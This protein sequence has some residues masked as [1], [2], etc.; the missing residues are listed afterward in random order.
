MRQLVLGLVASVGQV[1]AIGVIGGIVAS[2][3]ACSSS[4]APAIDAPRVDAVV[5]LDSARADAAVDAP[6]G[7]FV[8]TS[9]AWTEGNAIPVKHSCQGTN[10]SPPLAWTAAAGQGYA[11]VITDKSNALVHSVMWDIPAATQVLPE[12]IAK[13][14]EPPVPVGAKQTLAYDDR[15]RGYLGPCPPNQHTYEFALYAVSARP[16]PGL[17]LQSERAAVVAAV[18]AKQ[19][20]VAKL[21]GTFTP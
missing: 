6:T 11:L 17:T 10:V 2:S 9:A 13:L 3:T 19:T 15:T 4:P 1:V 16:L 7:T 20:A 18:K 5:A 12:N 14:A 8:L 21:T